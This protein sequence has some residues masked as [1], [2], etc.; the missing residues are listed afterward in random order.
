MGNRHK[1]AVN[2]KNGINFTLWLS[3]LACF[4]VCLSLVRDLESNNE[5]LSHLAIVY[6]ADTMLLVNL[7]VVKIQLVR[8]ILNKEK[9][10]H[11]QDVLW[12]KRCRH[13]AK[14]LG[15]LP[16]EQNDTKED[17]L[18]SNLQNTLPDPD[19]S[20]SVHNGLNT[21]NE[22]IGEHSVSEVEERELQ[23][24][25]HVS[26]DERVPND[27]KSR[28]LFIRNIVRTKNRILVHIFNVFG[29]ITVISV[30]ILICGN[31]VCYMEGGSSTVSMVLGLLKN[32]AY[33]GIILLTMVF[34]ECYYDV[35]FLNTLHN[36]FTIAVSAS[37]C[38]WISALKLFWPVQAL[39]G[40]SISEYGMNC[41]LNG[42]LG[43]FMLRIEQIVD[44]FHTECS[45]IAIGIIMQ[46][47]N[48][49]VTKASLRLEGTGQDFEAI[50]S[51]HT[52]SLSKKC[53]AHVKR[54]FKRYNSSRQDG[55]HGDGHQMQREHQARATEHLGI[56]WTLSIVANLLYLV[57]S[58]V[59]MFGPK[60]LHTTFQE[61]YVLWCLELIF[62][63]GFCILYMHQHFVARI[64]SLSSGEG[65][66]CDSWWDLKGH[67]TM[68]L[69]CASGVFSQGVFRIT[70]SIGV[71][72]SG[73]LDSDKIALAVFGTVYSVVTI[74][75]VWQ[76]TAFLL[77]IPRRQFVDPLE[78]KWVLICLIYIV[79]TCSTEW[80]ITSSYRETWSIQCLYF[81]E[82]TGNVIGV[83]L[84]PFETLYKLHTAMT[85]YEV[86]KD[87]RNFRT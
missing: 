15:L 39:L 71:L 63:F 22:S 41:K 6:A 67:E 35:I 44:P 77:Q 36:M 74:V 78:T 59:L 5:D 79:V 66:S 83:V 8:F 84:E 19:N 46:L 73:D 87:I 80:L 47:L 30:A 62:S 54:W 9:F 61:V 56:P 7:I 32:L 4:G 57:I 69:L 3:F 23:P 10:H 29:C 48:S 72:L 34:C 17:N 31:V 81:G 1:L 49:F 55:K 24:L 45:I 27:C 26:L 42:T 75:T 20:T 50:G 60:M 38:V 14:I 37:L 12:P 76:M 65:F 64:R 25:A 2:S 51:D 33:V 53:M 52:L 18:A 70:A 40:S 21:S 68:L 85:A 28:I 58:V 82:T 86:F 13:C 16:P 43:R 11:A